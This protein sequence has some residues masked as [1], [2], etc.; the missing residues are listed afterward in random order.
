MNNCEVLTLESHSKQQQTNAL[1]TAEL[2]FTL[3]IK[4]HPNRVDYNH[5]SRFT[6]APLRPSCLRCQL[7]SHCPLS[8]VYAA[9]LHFECSSNGPVQAKP[10]P[11]KFSHAWFARFPKYAKTRPLCNLTPCTCMH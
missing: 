5:I 7:P 10:R 4:Q 2:K 9:S 1:Q 3:L 6:P 8:P 11:A